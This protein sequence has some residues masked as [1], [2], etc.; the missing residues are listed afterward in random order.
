MHPLIK[1]LHNICLQEKQSDSEKDRTR[2]R[3]ISHVFVN[4]IKII[5]MS[6]EY[7]DDGRKGILFES[8]CFNI[9]RIIDIYKDDLLTVNSIKILNKI[10]NMITHDPLN[11]YIKQG[12]IYFT[13]SRLENELTHNVHYMDRNGYIN[14]AKF[15]TY[16]LLVLAKE[17]EKLTGS[18]KFSG[19]SF[20]DELLRQGFECIFA[21]NYLLD[22]EH[23]EYIDIVTKL[24]ELYTRS[25]SEV[26]SV[27]QWFETK[28]VEKYPVDYMNALISMCYNK[29]YQHTSDS[30]TLEA[31]VG[32]CNTA[33]AYIDEIESE[34]P[35]IWIYRRD[36]Y[37]HLSAYHYRL[38]DG[39]NSVAC[40]ERAL[41]IAQKKGVT[42]LKER[43]LLQSTY[44][45]ALSLVD[46][47]KE[48][49][50]LIQCFV[51][52]DECRK[53]NINDIDEHQN[54]IFGNYIGSCLDMRVIMP[55]AQLNDILDYMASQIPNAYKVNISYCLARYYL[56][57]QK[58]DEAIDILSPLLK[59][60]NI[61]K[62]IKQRIQ[63]VID[64]LSH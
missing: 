34:Y 52:F 40:A 8:Y 3:H 18:E 51:L 64:E 32:S 28:G 63:Q 11:F 24:P 50:Q 17:V 2:A 33:L 12:G 37:Q 61:E 42:S 14:I 41:A 56:V 30:S 10:R 16:Y 29:D 27:I 35:Y 31:A 59:L 20:S 26:A 19:L 46:Q 47:K 57:H 15:M 9:K 4:L 21:E 48:N 13:N 38:K 53:N 1:T 58:K 43:I 39:R 36:L 49:E 60:K 44:A 6:A 55:Q 22:E 25:Q 45:N 7:D 54:M 5:A 23:D 62:E